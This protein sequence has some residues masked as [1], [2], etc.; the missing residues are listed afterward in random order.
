MT[1]L[2]NAK[3]NKKVNKK[4]NLIDKF[5]KKSKNNEKDVSKSLVCENPNFSQFILDIPKY[6]EKANYKIND[7]IFGEVYNKFICFCGQ[8]STL[9]DAYDKLFDKDPKFKKYI[10]L[11]RRDSFRSFINNLDKEEMEK[12]LNKIIYLHFHINK[13]FKYDIN[14]K[15]KLNSEA[16]YMIP[17]LD[18]RF[19]YSKKEARRFFLSFYYKKAMQIQSIQVQ[20]KIL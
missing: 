9:K 1:K 7:C 3:S 5:N 19:E 8:H 12:F 10:K 15:W 11:Y 17:K 2:P 20:L 13:A 6:P 18:V 4:Q 16:E 14:L